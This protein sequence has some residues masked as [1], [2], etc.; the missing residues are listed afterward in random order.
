MVIL[1]KGCVLL[2]EQKVTI[3]GNDAEKSEPLYAVGCW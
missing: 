1:D 3:I 2:K